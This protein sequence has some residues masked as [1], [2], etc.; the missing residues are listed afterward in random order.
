M[1]NKILIIDDDVIYCKILEMILCGQYIL[2]MTKSSSEALAFFET[3][4]VPDLVIADINLPGLAGLELILLIKQKLNNNKTPI[5]V[6]S[7]MDDDNL[8]NE[9]LQKGVSDFLTKPIDRH[10]LKEK[11]AELI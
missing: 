4:D 3:K 1:K 5:I 8:K 9:L 11:I 2:F 10:S 6:I 7:G